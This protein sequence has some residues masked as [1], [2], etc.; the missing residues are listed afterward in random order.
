MLIMRRFFS[1]TGIDEIDEQAGTMPDRKIPGQRAIANKPAIFR[2]RAFVDR[3]RAG[4]DQH[5]D[6]HLNMQTISAPR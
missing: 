1:P 6:V 3:I 2:L 4:I 5:G